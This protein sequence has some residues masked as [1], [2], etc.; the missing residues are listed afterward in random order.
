MW[1]GG[2]SDAALSRA[3]RH[4]G[5]C[6]YAETPRSFGA[7]RDRIRELLGRDD[8]SY[9]YAVL[10]F[11][12]IDDDRETARARM[13]PLLRRHYGDRF[14][15][16]MD[17]LCAVGTAEDIR[18]RLGEYAQAGATELLL[19]PLCHPDDLDHQVARLATAFELQREEQDVP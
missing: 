12:S 3:S 16:A 1:I 18:V 11:T 7:K 9:D 8:A 14:A 17:V 13:E 6:A 19:S 10:V 15:D 4:R 5:W 2:R